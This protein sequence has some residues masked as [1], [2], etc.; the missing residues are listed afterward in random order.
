MNS[1]EKILMTGHGPSMRVKAGHLVRFIDKTHS[2][3]FLLR[4]HT[5]L[6]VKVD[7]SAADRRPYNTRWLGSK[8]IVIFDGVER[9]CT[10]YALEIVRQPK[11]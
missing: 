10:E 6:V 1:A 8:V 11:S 7:Q 2:A 9:A 5:G 3:Y 4:D